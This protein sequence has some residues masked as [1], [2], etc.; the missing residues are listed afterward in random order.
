MRRILVIGFGNPGRC[1]DGLGPA[2]AA[3][4]EGRSLP[5]VTV[6]SDY[7]LTVED[8]DSVAR[9]D[10]VVFADASVGGS[11]P[12]YFRR[13]QPHGTLGFSSHS[14]EPGEVLAL[15]ATLFDGTPEAY[16]LGIRGYAFNEFGEGLS[17][18]ASANLA[19][20][21]AFID[22]VLREDRCAT[23][24]CGVVN[25]CERDVITRRR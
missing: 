11:E 9:H 3:W 12:F 19:A 21:A 20:A 4:L 18:K 17:G 24:E 16:V 1:D 6:D 5:G 22:C 15:A 23:S 13:T 25:V 2:L 10:V 7:Q 8:A 14:V